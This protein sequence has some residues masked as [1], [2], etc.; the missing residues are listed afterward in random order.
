MFSET[1]MKI[2]QISFAV[3]CTLVIILGVLMA[4]YLIL[5]MVCAIFNL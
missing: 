3:L 5:V 2:L 4:A 1:I